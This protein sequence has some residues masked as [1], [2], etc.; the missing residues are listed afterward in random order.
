[1]AGGTAAVGMPLITP[2]YMELQKALH[3][4]GNYGKGVDADECARV[5]REIA[6]IGSTVLDYGCGNGHLGK[7]LRPDYN[8]REYDPC[9]DDKCSRPEQAEYV[10][11]ADVMEHIEPDLVETVISHL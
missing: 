3:A 5:I 6:P 7:L 4:T 1:M 8:V 10:V 9:L 2:E 11:C